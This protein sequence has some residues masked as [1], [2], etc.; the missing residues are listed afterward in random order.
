MPLVRSR[1]SHA[2]PRS[3]FVIVEEEEEDILDDDA[4]PHL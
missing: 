2:R 3:L 4:S 1:G